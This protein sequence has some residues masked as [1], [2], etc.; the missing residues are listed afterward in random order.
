MLELSDEDYE[1]LK[2][3]WQTVTNPFETNEKMENQGNRNYK[4]NNIEI[5]ELYNWKIQ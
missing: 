2:V 4:K 1:S 3:L 5:W